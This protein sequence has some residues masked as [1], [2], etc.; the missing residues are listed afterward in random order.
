M[1]LRMSACTDELFLLC[2]LSTLGQSPTST[3]YALT[4][5]GLPPGWEERKDGKGRTYYVNHNSRT[6]TWTRPIVQ[7]QQVW[8]LA[9]RLYAWDWTLPLPLSGPRPV[10]RTSSSI[11]AVFLLCVAIKNDGKRHSFATT[12]SLFLSF[13]LS[14]FLFC[15]TFIVCLPSLV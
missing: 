2:S 8:R 11:P 9:G 13:S 14:G 10:C 1:S 7:V 6:T 3:A 5:P 15:P 4:T 12:K